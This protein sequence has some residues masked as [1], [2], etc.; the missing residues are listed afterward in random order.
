VFVVGG[1]DDRIWPSASYVRKIAKR[2]RAHGHGHAT[3][4]VYRR[5]GHGVGIPLPNLRIGTE[6]AD[7]LINLGGSPAEDARARATEWPRL[8]QFLAGL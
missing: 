8:L 7:H 4:L 1:G 6:S 2:L 3:A 5:A